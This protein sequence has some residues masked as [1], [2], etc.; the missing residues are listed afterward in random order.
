MS[1]SERDK[2][3][4][5]PEQ[6][7]QIEPGQQPPD[8]P[9]VTPAF[10]PMRAIGA[11]MLTALGFGL[12]EYV[13]ITFWS[14]PAMGIYERVP[15]PAYTLMALAVVAT[16]MAIR[17]ALSLRSPHAKLGFAI[18]AFFACVVVAIGGGRFISYTLR[19]T[20]NPPFSVNLK[21]GDSFP[22]F[23]LADQNGVIHDGPGSSSSAATL[24]YVYRG[25][26]CPFARYELAD[27]GKLQDT[28]KKDG[29]EVVAIS[30]DPIDRSTMLSHYLNSGIPLLSDQKESLL[31]SLGL[32]QHHR[33]GEP[34]NA[35]PAF[36][37]VDRGGIVRWIF[38]SPYYRELPRP[39][40]LA[41]AVKAVA[42]AGN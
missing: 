37:I 39:E 7:E 18:L 21:P 36:F 14:S 5:T 38:T 6:I 19:G 9:W 23:A 16:L 34:D 41:D 11:I 13:L 20:L 42:K 2:P 24:I 28:L 15:W 12:Y 4:E 29:V 33:N 25:D 32:V 40:I 27:L 1:D 22:R 31:G 26:F 8:E 10:Q 30:A 35:I 17:I 3:A